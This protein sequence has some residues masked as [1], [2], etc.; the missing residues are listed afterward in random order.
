MKGLEGLKVIELT[1]YVAGPACPRTLA[2]LGATVYKVEPFEGD[3]YRNNAPGFGMSKTEFDDPAFDLCSTNKTWIS[4]NLKSQAGAELLDKMLKEADVLVTSFRDKGLEH[5]GLDYPSCKVKYPHLVW[6]QMRGYGWR[7]PEK[8]SRGFD[9]T[10]YNGRGGVFASLP[11]SDN[12]AP[13]NMP[14]GFGDFQ[15]SLALTAGICAALYR[16]EKTGL[17]DRVTVNLYHVAL[18]AQQIGLASTQFGD[19]W[20]KSRKSA[21]TPTNN[22]YKAGDGTWFVLC[23][24]SSDTYF[25]LIMHLLG[26][27][28]LIDDERYNTLKVMNS[29]GTNVDVIHWMEEAF[30]SHDF[31]YWE[32]V[33][34]ENGVAYH[35]L[36]HFEDC[37]VDQEAYDNDILRKLDYDEYGP[38]ALT[39]APIRLNSVGDP[40]LY[41]S[42][43]IGYDTAAVMREYGYSDEQIAQLAAEGAV[44]VYDGPE[45]PETVLKPSYGPG[46]FY[47]D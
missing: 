29:T 34:Q 36:Y 26:L 11:Q 39:T 10:A 12:F 15:C 14:N 17:G 25:P 46:N 37:L 45:L 44:K 40:V 21:A 18:W 9:N 38:K 1:S 28:H 35:K 8:D 32:K 30:E 16:R 13:T 23:M 2:E 4:L 3:D 24:G 43:P 7:G 6:A 20:P 47:D 42:R 31:A 22:T 33:F 27:D 19:H 5:L 41:R